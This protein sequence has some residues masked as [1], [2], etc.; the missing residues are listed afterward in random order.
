MFII[1]PRP[2]IGSSLFSLSHSPSGSGGET[3]LVLSSEVYRRAHAAN[4]AFIDKLEYVG[5]T[6]RRNILEEDDPTSPIGRGGC[7]AWVCHSETER[8]RERDTTTETTTFTHSERVQSRRCQR[9]EKSAVLLILLGGKREIGCPK[10]YKFP[11]QINR[12]G[13]SEQDDV[14][15]QDPSV[16][17]FQI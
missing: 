8:Q 13:Q 4:A 7:D 17:S 11:F 9:G 3:P 1:T 14:A 6:Y 10:R 15:I 16:S 2:P 5:V 12:G